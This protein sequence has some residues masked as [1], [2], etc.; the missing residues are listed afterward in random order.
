[1]AQERETFLIAC[2]ACGAKNRV[3]GER[4]GVRGKCGSCHAQLPPL[5]SHPL[6][7]DDGSFDPF[8]GA[9]PGPVLVEFWAP[10]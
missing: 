7:L 2:P 3:P 4:E 9:Y 6:Q 10:W 1:M 8:V 5:Y